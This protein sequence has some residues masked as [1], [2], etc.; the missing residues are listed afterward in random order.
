MSD[1]LVKLLFNQKNCRGVVLHLDEA[2]S[3]MVSNQALPVCVKRLLGQMVTGA[4]MLA[5]GLKF[6]GALILQL[7]GDGPVK[8]AIVEVR[9]GLVVRATA[10][11]RVPPETLAEDLNFKAL[12][13]ENGRGR[14][15]IILDMDDRAVGDEPYQGVVELHDEGVGR[16]LEGY[17]ESSAQLQTRLWLTA[18]VNAAG[19]ILLQRLPAEGGFAPEA[20]P[21]QDTLASIALFAQ[22]VKPEELLGL[23]ADQLAQRLFW[24]DNPRIVAEL[25]PTF[26]CRCSQQGIESMVKNLGET[27]ARAILAER[28]KIEVTCEFCGAHYMLDAIDVEMLFRTGLTTAASQKH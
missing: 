26:R 12:V 19:G 7:Q 20:S 13:N 22:T 21:E 1:K 3:S 16:T 25:S 27:E 2:W 6:Q 8:L 23:E 28:G 24:E 4:V 11:L 17:M 9:T 5:S 15:A 18:D 10:Q 14:C